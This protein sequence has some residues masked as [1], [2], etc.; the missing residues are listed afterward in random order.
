MVEE[1]VEILK[2]YVLGSQIYLAILLLPTGQ[3]C[4]TFFLR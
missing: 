3:K 1:E 2:R 4:K